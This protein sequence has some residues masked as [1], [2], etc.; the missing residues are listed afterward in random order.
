MACR[1]THEPQRE[2]LA[3]SV[4][5]SPAK[6]DT[7]MTTLKLVIAS[8][9]LLVAATVVAQTPSLDQPLPPLNIEKLG[10]LML[11]GEE[12]SYAP[13]D[14]QVAPGKVHVVQYFSG[15]SSASKIFEPFTDLLMA[16]F[17]NGQ[18]HVTTIINLDAAM[19]GTSGFIISEVKSNKVKYPT[20][21]LVLDKDGTGAENWQLGKKGAALAIVGNNGKI[22]FFSAQSLS[23]EQMQTA[24]ALVREEIE[25]QE[26]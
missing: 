26:S 15:T 6:M 4:N 9:A 14:S 16:N 19:W 21:S 18:Y 17:E 24:V 5:F 22:R 10:E 12:Y 2:N 3:A 7:A 20:S 13:W 11:E 25:S 8:L 1:A 23:E